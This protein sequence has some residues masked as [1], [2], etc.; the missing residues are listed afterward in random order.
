M[1]PFLGGVMQKQERVIKGLQRNLTLSDRP[2]RGFP[3]FCIRAWCISQ[4]KLI[5][6]C[7]L[8]RGSLQLSLLFGAER[9]KIAFKAPCPESDAWSFSIY[10]HIRHI[11]VSSRFD[12]TTNTEKWTMTITIHPTLDNAT[13]KQCRVTARYQMPRKDMIEDIERNICS[14]SSLRQ[15]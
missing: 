9:E 2:A 5:S 15:A 8:A 13:Q 7:G 11:P 10:Q 4:T 1:Y 14:K 6:R 12:S 3:L